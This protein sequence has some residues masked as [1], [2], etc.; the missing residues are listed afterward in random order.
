QIT[1]GFTS[2]FH[3]AF[4]ILTAPMSRW[5]IAKLHRFSA[6]NK[7]ARQQQINE[8]LYAITST[9]CQGVKAA[10]QVYW[11]YASV[12]GDAVLAPK[13]ASYYTYANAIALW[14]P[15]VLLLAISGATR[16]AVLAMVPFLRYK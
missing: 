6:Y 15:P 11:M 14:S 8:T 13:V 16:R 4:L 2:F 1:K 5:C 3:L 7:Q 10:Q 12:I 9:I